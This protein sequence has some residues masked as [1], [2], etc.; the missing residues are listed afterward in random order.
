MYKIVKFLGRVHCCLEFVV[1]KDDEGNP[2][3]FET[4][5]DAEDYI[6]D[7]NLENFY[8]VEVTVLKK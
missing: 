7:N 2:R 5:K 8:A 4:M 3:Q 1:I 6:R